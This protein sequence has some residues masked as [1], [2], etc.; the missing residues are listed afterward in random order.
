VFSFTVTKIITSGKFLLLILAT[1][2]QMISKINW[3]GITMKIAMIESLGE[4]E[5]MPGNKSNSDYRV[6][7]SQLSVGNR[8]II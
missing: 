5:I 2:T 3:I 6:V 4:M 8:Q 7:F 1:C